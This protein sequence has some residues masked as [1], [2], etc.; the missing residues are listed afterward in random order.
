[1]CACGAGAL[2]EALRSET[3]QYTALFLVA[4]VL[5]VRSVAPH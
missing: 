1:M 3:M 5:H 4:S 2:M